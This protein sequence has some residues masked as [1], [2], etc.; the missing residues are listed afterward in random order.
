MAAWFREVR[1]YPVSKQSA[2]TGNG[3]QGGKGAASVISKRVLKAITIAAGSY[4]LK[5]DIQSGKEEKVY[6]VSNQ[7]I[8]SLIGYDITLYWIEYDKKRD[9][10]GN[11]N[12]KLIMMDLTSH[13]VTELQRGVGQDQIDPPVLRSYKNK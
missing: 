6:S 5:T 8:N 3:S 2:A 13:K 11:I 10:S 1:R 7:I 9:E 4:L 12:W